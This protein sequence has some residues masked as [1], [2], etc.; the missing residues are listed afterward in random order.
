[1]SHQRLKNLGIQAIPPSLV[2]IA[3]RLHHIQVQV[4]PGTV[5]GH[6]VTEEP[7]D[8]QPSRGHRTR[9]A[10]GRPGV[11]PG[12]RFARGNIEHVGSTSSNEDDYE[13]C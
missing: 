11:L 12:S 7:E 1:M 8:W 10:E 6:Y 2:D 3:A 13:V 5:S 9:G 4:P